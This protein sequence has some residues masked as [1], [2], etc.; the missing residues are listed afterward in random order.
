MIFKIGNVSTFIEYEEPKYIVDEIEKKI[1]TTI[2]PLDP[3][4]YRK[5]AFKRHV[6]DGRVKFYDSKNKSFPT[7]LLDDVSDLIKSMQESYPEIKMSLEDNREL[8]VATN[9][10]LPDVIEFK[11]TPKGNLTLD[12]NDP[13]RGYQYKA[14]DFALREQRGFINLAVNSGKAASNDTVIPLADGTTKRIGDVQVGDYILGQD[15][16]PT[17]VLAV[18]PQPTQELYKVTLMDG[19]SFTV[20]G[21]HLIPVYI[22]AHKEPKTI[23]NLQIKTLNEIKAVYKYPHKNPQGYPACN[24]KYSLPLA[25]AV[26][27]PEQEHEIKP[28]IF[29]TLLA[30]GLLSEDSSS[31][32][33]TLVNGYLKDSI[34]NRLN[35]LKAIF[36]IK[37]WVIKRPKLGVYTLALQVKNT[38]LRDIVISLVDSLGIGRTVHFYS[39]YGNIHDM[40]LIKLFTPERIWTSTKIDESIKGLVYKSTRHL[41]SPIKNIQSVG[42]G[43]STC[44]TVDNKDHLYLLN[45]YIVTHNTVVAEGIIQEDLKHLKPDERIFFIVH[46]KIIA[47]QTKKRFEESLH[48]PIGFWGDGKKDI[49]QVTCCIVTTIASALKDPEEVVKLTSK[50][51]TTLKRMVSFYIPMFEKLPNKKLAIK[52]YIRNNQPRYAYEESIWNTFTDMVLPEITDKQIEKAFEGYKKQYANLIRKKN[53]KGYDKYEDAV[54]ILDTVKVV[55]AD[56]CVTKDTLIT[57]NDWTLKPIALIKEGDMLL[58]HNKVLGVKKTEKQPIAKVY[59]KHTL[60]KTSLTHPLAVLDEDSNVTYKAVMKIKPRDNLVYRDEVTGV[61]TYPEVTKISITEEEQEL[62]DLSTENHSFF[63]NNLLSHNCQHTSSDS[64]QRVM[65]NLVNARQRIGLSGTLSDK[66]P[67]KWTK[68]KSLFSNKLFK[69]TNEEMINKGIS[70][71]PYIQFIPI[72]YP[73]NLD[74]QI[75][76]SLPPN[77]DEKNNALM[78]YQEAYRQGI[79]ENDYRNNVIAKLIAKLNA[80]GKSSL[81]VVKSLEHGHALQ[82]LLL[83]MGIESAFLEGKLDTDQR[84]T[85]LNGVKSG[86]IK[87]VF[88]TSL[89]NE[90]MDI[91]NL[92][93]LVYASSGKS[94]IEVLQRVGRVLRKGK[95]KDTTIVFDF[96]DNMS[97]VL[98]KQSKA[99]KHIYQKEKFDIL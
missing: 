91:P 34:A 47:Y 45:D 36:D 11:D 89:V 44:F 71:K 15:G 27:Y 43:E 33:K 6:W 79:I 77:F 63:S 99:R 31:D 9:K 13:V 64:Y 94:S 87:V 24:Y 17:K 80:T 5:M 38:L 42:Q 37:G 2:D 28:Y 72:D 81:I 20:T 16:K 67:I 90:G 26:E 92:K 97:E 32:M 35:L 59:T 21:E 29:G 25:E 95:D 39:K 55:I 46:N 49:Q 3:Q 41:Y 61:I 85:I 84:D 50:K 22:N 88:G 4:R 53:K 19:R 30:K 54:N 12:P 10:T 8:P 66:D 93:Y 52:N 1:H 70:A 86:R 83:D 65:S 48:I 62:Y 7:G 68:I 96:M 75:K 74:T 56:E 76:E 14:V 78:L 57:M 18:Y 82:D 40:W 98:Y 23:D 69:S 73:K 58:N 51:D 60:L